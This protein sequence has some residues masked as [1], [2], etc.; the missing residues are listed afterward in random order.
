MIFIEDEEIESSKQEEII[1][2]HSLI[3]GNQVTKHEELD[4]SIRNFKFIFLKNYIFI[5]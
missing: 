4:V 1:Q 5:F 2:D 3:Y